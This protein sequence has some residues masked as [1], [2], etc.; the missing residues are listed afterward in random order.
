M[1][2]EERP[3]GAAQARPPR[4][5]AA[6]VERRAPAPVRRDFD[7]FL[8]G[9]ARG[10]RSGGSARWAQRSSQSLNRVSPEARAST[11]A[12]TATMAAVVAALSSLRVLARASSPIAACRTLA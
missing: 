7:R 5:G 4:R 11:T 6:R 1:A 3:A 2:A 8:F 10:L 9:E 12:P